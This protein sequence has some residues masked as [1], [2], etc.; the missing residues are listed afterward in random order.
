MA[1]KPVRPRGKP[2]QRAAASPPSPPRN[3]LAEWVE[4]AGLGEEVRHALVMWFARQLVSDQYA[5]LEQ[6]SHQE[7]G[8]P[9]RKV[10]VDLPLA[11]SSRDSQRPLFLRTLL[12][13][14]PVPMHERSGSV[15][16]ELDREAPPARLPRDPREKAAGFLVI[17]GP[18]QGKSTLGQLACQ[19]HRAALL[20]PFADHLSTL[21]REALAHFTEPAARKEIGAPRAPLLPLPI[22]LP[23]AAAWLARRTAPDT[24]PSATMPVL[25]E[26]LAEQSQK[27]G[28][29]VSPDAL[30]RLLGV[31]PFLLVLDGF[32]EVGA[33]E[34]RSRLVTAI[35]E[36]LSSEPVRANHGLVVATTRPQG[37]AGELAQI[38]ASLGTVHLASLTREEGL[39]YGRK[40]AA[41]KLAERPD[42]RERVLA[43]LEEAAREEATARLM[44]TPLQVTILVALVQR[45]GRVPSERWG[46][47]KRYFETIYDRE[48]ERGTYAA[49][50]L[51]DHRMH[52]ER[53]HARAGLLLQVESEQAGGGDAR[54]SR[55]RLEAIANAVLA[56]DEIDEETRAGLVRRITRAAEERLVFLVE[57][58]PG[59]FGFEIRSLQELMAAWALAADG[60]APLEA[61]LLQVAPASMF[62]NVTLFLAS[63]L[64]TEGSPLRAVL[65]ERVCPALERGADGEGPR[66]ARAGA[67]LAL[68]VLEEGSALK[69]PRH[70]RRLMEQACELLDLPPCE[71]QVRLARVEMEAAAETLRAAVETRLGEPSAPRALGA[72]VTLIEAANAGARWAAEI[73][74][75]VW[76]SLE[77]A[78]QVLAACQQSGALLGPWLVERIEEQPEKVPPT[79]LRWWRGSR[80][81]AGQWTQGFTRS[82]TLRL[83]STAHTREGIGVYFLSLARS[84]DFEWTAIVS[85]PAPPPR[86]LP[87][88]SAAKFARKPSATSLAETLRVLA[89]TNGWEQREELADFSPWPL[90]ACLRS[91]ATPEDW[92]RYATLAEAGDLLDLEAWRAAEEYWISHLIEGEALLAPVA[93]LPWS[94]AALENAPPIG[95]IS[96][97]YV[98]APTAPIVD[99]LRSAIHPAAS[100]RIQT[101]FARCLMTVLDSSDPIQLQGIPTAELE[102]ASELA[103][104]APLSFAVNQWASSPGES[105]ETDWL[106]RLGRQRT[107][108]VWWMPDN[109]APLRLFGLFAAHPDRHGLLFW[110]RW[111]VSTFDLSALLLPPPERAQV[112]KAMA[113]ARPEDPGLRADAALLQ[114]WLGEI[115][116]EQLPAWFDTIAQQAHREPELWNEAAICLRLSE[117]PPA[118][119]EAALVALLARE[120]VPWSASAEAHRA[121]RNVLQ[122]RRSG[123]ADPATWKRLSLPLPLPLQAAASARS[124]TLPD[125]PVS[126]ARIGFTNVRG[127]RELKLD[128]APPASP[129][130]GQWA[131]FLGPNGSGK[132]TL[133]RS[134]ALALRNLADVKIWP[135]GTFATPWVSSQAAVAKATIAV[136]LSDGRPFTATIERNG[137]ETPSREPRNAPTPFPVLGYGCHRGSALG[138]ASREVSF[139]EDDGPEIAT[140]FDE[141][142]SVLHAETW[143]KE[144]DGAAARNPGSSGPIYDAIREA[145]KKLLDIEDIYVRDRHVWVIEEAG[146]QPLRFASLSDGYLTTAGWF[147]D[148]VA[149]WI[150]LAYK[151]SIPVDGEILGRMTGVVLLDEIDLY[152]HPRW[153]IEILRRVKERLPRM[154][155]L[156]TTH[157][158]LTLVGARPEEIWILSA[159]GGHVT[160]EPG[161]ESPM[162]LT[163]GQIYSRYFGIKSLYPNELGEALRRYGFLSGDPM[164]TDEEQAEM[165]GL[166][167]KLRAAGIDPGWEE[168]PRRKEPSI[169][170][171]ARRAS[172]RTSRRPALPEKGAKSAKSP[173]RA[174]A[175][176][177]RRGR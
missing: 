121:L 101:I 51:R 87:W 92:L 5:K 125:K 34:D 40:L 62:R 28:A 31:A 18:G 145:L 59:R 89:E 98:Q 159:D 46:L 109:T 49:P 14:S 119:R 24:A 65:A 103:G 135:K 42:D 70:A 90:A 165:E 120:D 97:A 83:R 93:D 67:L 127:L 117:A 166:R 2:G 162:L 58:Q 176:P 167:E 1:S 142:A 174:A 171:P 47:F 71:E 54:L 146:A 168:T 104:R 85:M 64:F 15:A 23:E 76:A 141:G 128:L 10:F 73:G 53:I 39:A 138:G 3:L 131:I 150:E 156:V 66:V 170:A 151:Q 102:R 30:G 123:L 68:E 152:L 91:A 169:P 137:S 75:R 29:Q 48:V 94:R 110:L 115:D 107:I 45:M 50:L 124:F 43:G 72:W 6:G 99:F 63:K 81:P 95:G 164:R 113:E 122:S 155:F 82:Q 172:P 163:G 77:D 139:S 158:P 133:L 147:L 126:L 154:T 161:T 41:T 38:G 27:R 60:D 86:W 118:F 177:R 57:P 8:I 88:M 130:R 175:P 4:R 19:V 12:A 61:R 74:Q 33:V 25:L 148:L 56:E 149:R 37:Y 32:D 114:A 116:R 11:E 129:D 143:L 21:Q 112:A 84:A 52:V 105:Q 111:Y 96:H 78:Q 136:K 140:L 22:S 44:T 100:H 79:T 20:T 17:G 153:Q 160:A 16:T 13:M 35:A 144:W 69:Q 173:E 55:E 36:L 132:T 108:F 134:I 7:G 106:D 26:W 80:I 9:L 157:N